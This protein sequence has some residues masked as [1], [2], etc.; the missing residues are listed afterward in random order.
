VAFDEKEPDK[1]VE[2]ALAR[3]A[4]VTLPIV[5]GRQ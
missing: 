1:N 4:C 2:I 5:K 3:H